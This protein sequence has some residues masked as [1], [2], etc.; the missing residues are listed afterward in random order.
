MKILVTFAVRAEFAPWQRRRNFMRLP[1]DSPVVA[2]KSLGDKAISAAGGVGGPAVAALADSTPS[3][4]RELGELHDF[5]LEDL[6]HPLDEAATA[7][8]GDGDRTQPRRVEQ[9][10]KRTTLS[11][12][13]Y[14]RRLGL[15]I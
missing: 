7:A 8:T 1:G 12:T 15:I 4:R 10:A 6:V 14:K 3:V 9:P 2:A 13:D 11:I 5:D